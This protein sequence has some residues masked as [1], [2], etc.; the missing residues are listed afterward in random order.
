MNYEKNLEILEKLDSELSEFVSSVCI[1]E[2]T[3]DDVQLARTKFFNI[4]SSNSNMDLFLLYITIAVKNKKRYK[5]LKKKRGDFSIPDRVI[6]G[7][8]SAIVAG[9]NVDV[10]CKFAGITK[11]TL[12]NRIHAR[13]YDNVKEFFKSRRF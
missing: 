5:S 9:E 13:G 7:V 6:D 2:F 12:Y 11:S 4:I 1:N 10:A 8:I 3:E